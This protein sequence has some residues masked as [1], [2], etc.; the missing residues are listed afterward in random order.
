MTDDGAAALKRVTLAPNSRILPEFD[1]ALGGFPTLR[2]ASFTYDDPDDNPD[3]GLITKQVPLEPSGRFNPEADVKIDAEDVADNVTIRV[4]GR[5]VPVGT[6]VTIT[7]AN[8]DDSSPDISATLEGTEEDP[9]LTA[10]VKI[11]PGF[12]VVSARASFTV[13]P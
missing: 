10:T 11:P 5:N 3:A 7:V 6:P 9:F 4:E 8:E 13:N 1:F 12:S 2:I